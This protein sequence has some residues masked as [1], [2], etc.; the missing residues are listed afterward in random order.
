MSKFQY[1]SYDDAK[2]EIYVN[3]IITM[4]ELL[5]YLQKTKQFRVDILKKFNPKV[6]KEDGTID[7]KMSSEK[8][9]KIKLRCIGHDTAKDNSTNILLSSNKIS[10]FRG[11]CLCSGKGLN[12]V[13]V[14]LIFKLGVDPK[15]VLNTE[16]YKAIGKERYRAI[17][18]LMEMKGYKILQVTQRKRMT[19]EQKE[20]KLNQ[21]ILN[22]AAD[23]Y[24]QEFLISEEAQNYFFEAKYEEVDKNG[25][26]VERK[27]RAFQY[28]NGKEYAMEQVKR[29][30][31]GFAPE[32]FPATWLYD[33]LAPN[34]TTEELLRTS[35]IRWVEFKDENDKVREAKP[36][37]FHSHAVV[38][39]YWNRRHVTNLYSRALHATNEWKHL[40]LAGSV[41]VP[42]HFEEATRH[43]VVNI[44]E[45]EMTWFTK[46]LFGYENTLGNR[47]TN[48]LLPE[49]V[50]MLVKVREESAGEYCQTIV[51]AFDGD[52]PGRQATL[53]TGEMLVKEGFTVKVVLMPEGMDHNDILFEHKE[54]AKSIYAKLYAETVSFHTFVALSKVKE[55]MEAAAD[56]VHKLVEIKHII[57]QNG[58]TSQ[59]ELRLIAE[60]FA[61]K[62][63]IPVEDIWGEWKKEN[64]NEEAFHKENYVFMT[65]DIESYYLLKFAFKQKATYVEDL[66]FSFVRN[67]EIKAKNIVVDKLNYK[68]EELE[69]IEQFCDVNEI[70][71]LTFSDLSEVI[72]IKIDNSALINQ[73][74]K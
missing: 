26:K 67:Q 16:A 50:A 34:Y 52:E 27:G 19:K 55:K 32:S 63:G 29:F 33:K 49:H 14:Y 57:L 13:Q 47:G 71:M 1:I 5:I 59:T 10:C 15:V 68:E 46:I 22:L 8:N 31:V 56:Q 72:E 62:S 51:L 24:H 45:G 40:R 20:A 39:P 25:E 69:L 70:R 28:V 9:G 12:I 58:I 73:M 18:E 6:V 35:V 4:D 38:L 53:K 74:L 60:E 41:D 65:N 61:A 54:K 48:G 43:A 3:K 66:S 2:T 42:I 64:K 23:L 30:K 37:D 44:V 17:A 36:F 7:L 21:E 11:G